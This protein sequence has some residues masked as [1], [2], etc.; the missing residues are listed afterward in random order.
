MKKIILSIEERS[1]WTQ[2]KLWCTIL[3]WGILSQ[4]VNFRTTEGIIAS[5]E[6]RTN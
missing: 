4:Q 3:S 1:W 6:R 2:D 5:Y